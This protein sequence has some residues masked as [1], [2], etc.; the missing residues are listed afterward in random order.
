MAARPTS[1]AAAARPTLTEIG[2]AVRSAT[3]ARP[4]AI[5]TVA[6]PGGAVHLVIHSIG[7]ALAAARAPH[8]SITVGRTGRAGDLS[9]PG[10]GEVLVVG[11]VQFATGAAL[12]ALATLAEP[13]TDGGAVVLVHRLGAINQ[14]LAIATLGARRANAAFTLSRSTVAE[15]RAGT[16]VTAAE[17]ERRIAATAGRADLLAALELD[18]S[19]V[20]DVTA[21]LSVVAPAT[22]RVAELL[23]F[24]LP[25]D[26]LPTVTADHDGT[27]TA[28]PTDTAVDQLVVEGLLDPPD[29]VAGSAPTPTMLATVAEAVRTITTGARAG[30]GDR[31]AR[32]RRQQRAGHRP[33][34]AAAHRRRST[35]RRARCTA[36]ADELAGVD[37]AAFAPPGW[38]THGR[39]G[40]PPPTSRSQRPSPPW[41]PGSRTVRWP[42]CRRY[43][44][45]AV[46]RADAVVRAAAWVAL[47]DLEAAAASL[48]LSVLRPLAQWAR[49]GAGVPVVDARRPAAAPP[50]RARVRCGRHTRRG[51]RHLGGRRPR[52]LPRC[53]PA[54]RVATSRRGGCAPVAGHGRPGGCAPVRS[55][56]ISN[57]PNGWC[58]T[59]RRATWW[60]RAPP[61]APADVGVARRHPRTAR[62]RCRRAR[63]RGRRR[64]RTA[65]GAV[66]SG[67]ACSIAVLDPELDA[68]APSAAAALTVASAS[69]TH[70]Y[71]LRHHHRHRRCGAVPAWPAPTN[72]WHRPSGPSPASATRRR[73]WPIS[74]GHACVCR[75]L[76][77]DDLIRPPLPLARSPA[78]RCPPTTCSVGRLPTRSWRSPSRSVPGRRPRS[79]RQ[80]SSSCRSGWPTSLAARGRTVV[81]LRRSTHPDRERR[82]PAAQALAPVPSAAGPAEA[83]RTRRSR[84]RAA[85]RAGT[86]VAQLV[87]EGRTHREIGDVVHLR[88]DGGAPRRT[89]PHQAR[90][91]FL[92]RCSPRSAYLELAS[93]PS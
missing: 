58:S 20:P 8:R 92:P 22:R 73:W 36:A 54:R 79:R 18:G 67:V 86:R 23:A 83:R 2:E 60:S 63:R 77:C 40:R 35:A 74:R 3:A 42:C 24:G 72:C 85:E 80:R 93:S 37:P 78:C 11:E 32:E 47:G 52:R 4:G 12:E 53:R 44:P 6:C 89:H 49:I 29:T 7:A 81:R 51:R 26:R 45:E 76:C 39:P 62:R 5:V 13:D 59:D 87:L 14:P 88:Q 9:P 66:A 16:K 82:P 43:R 84:R 71:D 27:G 30:G 55:S 1:P 15:V 61:S 46:D 33:G 50:R 28:D 10:A 48:D 21:R 68:L 57:E 91:W 17:A 56:T 90:R 75:A 65:R 70:L 31:A 38:T 64:A 69:G 19:L 25:V 41:G 34:H